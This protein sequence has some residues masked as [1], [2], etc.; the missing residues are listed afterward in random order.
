M[1]QVVEKGTGLG[2]VAVEPGGSAL[3]DGEHP[4]LAVLAIAHDQGAGGGS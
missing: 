2:E 4:A 3:A 1:G